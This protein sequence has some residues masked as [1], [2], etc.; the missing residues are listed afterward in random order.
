MYL[1]LQQCQCSTFA[2]SALFQ[3]VNA[4][5]TGASTTAVMV[6]QDMLGTEKSI[7]HMVSKPVAV[8]SVTSQQP[9]DVA[10]SQ[11]MLEEANA[12]NERV[13]EVLDRDK[14]VSSINQT[15]NS[16]YSVLTD[17]FCNLS[18]IKNSKYM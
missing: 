10:V 13:S 6:T 18:W 8:S 14:V 4:S 3:L 7:K 1:H 11:K 5:A 2:F 9:P 12:D 15:P 17:F 16:S